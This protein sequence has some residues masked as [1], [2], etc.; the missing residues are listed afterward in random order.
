MPRI[1]G[2]DLAVCWAYSGGSVWLEND[3]RE[4]NYSRDV[5]D[6]NATAGNDTAAVHLPT[7]ADG[8]LSLNMLGTSSMGTAHY[9]GLAERT[10][11][12][13]HWY[14]EGT[15]A[16]KPYAYQPAYVKSFSEAWPYDDVVTQDIAWMP[17]GGITRG[18]VSG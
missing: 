4:F 6:A 2:H 16:G 9:A 14:G 10:E 7:Y 18:A 5:Q 15:A 1:T 12:T 17:Q 11:G 8:D 3:Y 13:V